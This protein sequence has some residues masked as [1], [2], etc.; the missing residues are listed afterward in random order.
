MRPRA[1]TQTH[2]LTCVR[3]IVTRLCIRTLTVLI[4]SISVAAQSAPRERNCRCDVGHSEAQRSRLGSAFEPRQACTR[5]PAPPPR[6][7]T[8]PTPLSHHTCIHN[9]GR[10]RDTNKEAGLDGTSKPWLGAALHPT[11]KAAA[12]TRRLRAPGATDNTRLHPKGVVE[13][14]LRRPTLG[15]KLSHLG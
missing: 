4:N 6:G 2:A 7:D 14:L 12:T 1:R 9:P 13:F 5:P 8:K 11:A 10:G 15:P 3:N